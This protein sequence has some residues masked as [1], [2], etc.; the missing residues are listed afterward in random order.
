MGS[1]AAKSAAGFKRSKMISTQ[2]GGMNRPRTSE[3]KRTRKNSFEENRAKKWG[4]I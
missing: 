4:G 3:D 1:T 2:I